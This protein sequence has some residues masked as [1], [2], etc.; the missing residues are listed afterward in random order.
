MKGDSQMTTFSDRLKEAMYAQNLKQIDLVHIA[1]ENNVK[2]G[3]SHVSQ[4]VSGKTVPRNDIL[5]FLA[6]TLHVDA[7]WLLGDSQE[8]F[9][10][11]ENNSVAPKTPSTTKTSGSV[12]T[13]NSSK[14]GTTPMK[15]TITDKNDNDNA[16]SSAMHIFKKS[17]KLDN[18]L[19]DV[20]GP[21]VEEAARME[22]RGTHV[23]KLNIG[24]PAPFGFRTP[25]EVIYD[26][27]QQLSDCEG[28]SPSQGLFSAR[29]AIMQYSQIKKLP[30]VTIN[31]IYTGNGVSELINLCMSALLDN[32]DEIL[33]PSPDYPLWTACAT[34][35]G[36][37]AV[38]YICDEQSDWYPD[39]E[40]MRRKITDRTKAL[41]II[42]P[43]NPTGYL[44]TRREM[45]QIRDL[46]KK[47]D[48]FLFSDEVY[49]EF[50]YTGSPYISA[51]HLEGIENNVVLIDSVSKRYS[52]CGIRIGALITKNKE[53]RDAVMKFCQARLSP[54]LIGQIAAEA[55]LD[56]PEEYSR[57]TYD[58]YVERRKC[59]IDGLNRIPGVYSPIP[60]GAFY[61][62]AKLPVDDSD[63]F[64]AWCL[65]DFEYE[66][67]TVFMAPASGFYTTPGSGINEVR[68]AYVLKKE[69]LTRALF[70]LQK[71]L[72]AYP[73][74]T[75]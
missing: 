58:E 33:I 18:V 57:E 1:A 2:L 67:Q 8:N 43:N 61:T 49:R 10:A 44:Y 15:K 50:I 28:Y 47:Y 23:L 20:R 31:D 16:G 73:G 6:D 39:I 45:N 63:K 17:S 38:H 11:R 3:K 55:S 40:D 36:G 4:Y 69:D 53:I 13:S 70:V 60:M 22:E 14:R 24:N 5:H 27:S 19:Y 9:T 37:K 75:E 72:E 62:V 12:G 34:L 71:A 59:L 32:G 25:D 52:E 51:C 56:A 42:N 54:P 65:S 64:C 74:R 68:I 26:M 41:V 7:D 35:A 48:L 66:G 21:V 29:K 46:V 30:N